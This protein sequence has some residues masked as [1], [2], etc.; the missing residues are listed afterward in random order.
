MILAALLAPAFAGELAERHAYERV[1][2]HATRELRVYDGWYT[3]LLVRGTRMDAEVWAAQDARMAGITGGAGPAPAHPA[4][5]VV[6]LTASGQWKD[7][8]KFSADGSTPW[9]VAL[10][11]GDTPCAAP[12]TLDAP[13]KVTD[14]DRVRFP[15]LTE[16]DRLVTITWAADAC[17]GAVPDSLRLVSAR[18]RGELRWAP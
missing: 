12:L 8:L 17:A 2:A 1:V 16:W 9:T 4:G 6:V 14:A 10:F 3:A 13:K 5:P 15:H 7:E 18:G 11:A